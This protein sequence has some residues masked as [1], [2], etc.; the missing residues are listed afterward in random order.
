MIKPKIC[1]CTF[2]DSRLQPTLKRIATEAKSS[3]FFDEVFIYNEFNLNK[4]FKNKYK[5]LLKYNIR[6]Y[7]Y[8]IWK[9]FIIQDVLS[10]LNDG[11]ILLYTDSGCSINK[12]GFNK[13]QE[14][15]KLVNESQL[16]IL[17]VSL[18]NSF[19]ESKY[20]KGDLFDY[21]KVR[22][23]EA[24][25]NS[26]QIQS[27]LILIRKNKNVDTFFKQFQ[28]VYEEDINFVNDEPSKKPNFLDFITH[29][30]DQSVFSVLFKI[31]KGVTIPLN[32]VWVENNED[33]D[34]LK[35]KPIWCMRRKNKKLAGLKYL[36]INWIKYAIG[37]KKTM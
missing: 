16:G 5:H 15:I 36:F 2:S 9:V 17:A 30:H 19:V 20:T 6:G 3:G 7:G 12:S 26:P 27:G 10:K 32:E 22:D 13:F 35:D 21:L 31:H 1:F 23:N 37:F 24:I 11:D 29:R 14:Y 25:Y 8:W 34:L 28:E 18:E 4:D 33:V